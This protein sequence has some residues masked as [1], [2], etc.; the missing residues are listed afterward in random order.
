MVTA[1]SGER[2]HILGVEHNTGRRGSIVNKTLWNIVV[3]VA[4]VA[5]VT[6]Y[7]AIQALA[8]NP[9]LLKTAVGWVA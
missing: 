4:V 9:D 5:A 3:A 6:V 7:A 2:A 8:I 1:M